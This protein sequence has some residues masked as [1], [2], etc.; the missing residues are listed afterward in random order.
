MSPQ[1][2]ML[3]VAVFIYTVMAILTL[4]GIGAMIWLTFVD[5]TPPPNFPPRA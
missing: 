2:D 5:R 4:L 1:D 3:T